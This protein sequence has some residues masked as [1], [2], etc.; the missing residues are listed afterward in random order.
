MTDR[1]DA[2]HEGTDDAIREI[3]EVTQVPVY[4]NKHIAERCALGSAALKLSDDIR[5]AFEVGTSIN[6]IDDEL[7]RLVEKQDRT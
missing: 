1:L 2:F 6:A 5:S 3:P 7:A 4:V